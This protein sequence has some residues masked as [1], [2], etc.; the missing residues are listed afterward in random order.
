MCGRYTITGGEKELEER[1]HAEFR[2]GKWTPRYNAA[3][4]QDLPIITNEHPDE[5]VAGHWGFVPF[6]VKE[7]KPSDE[8]INARAET[9]TEKPSFKQAVQKRRCLILADGFYEWKKSVPKKIPYRII[10]ADSKPFAFAGIWELR[11][12][13]EGV[14][15]P[16]FAIITVEPNEVMAPIHNRMPAILG[17][18]QEKEWLAGEAPH[19]DFLKPYSGEMKTY[20]VSTL[21]NNVKNNVEDLIR[22]HHG[23]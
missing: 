2:Y 7:A 14:E 6:W 10:L 21:V 16:H 22:E 20:P 3:P 8:I 5:I 11:K 18:D 13:A 4:S 9:I 1:F 17:K 12:N 19:L 15:E 23:T